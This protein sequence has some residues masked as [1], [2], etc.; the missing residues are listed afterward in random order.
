MVRT[1]TVVA[2]GLIVLGVVAM[3]GPTFGFSTV[4]GD[5][6]ISVDTSEGGDAMV[7]LEGLVADDEVEIN[8]ENDEETVI[9]IH[10]NVGSPI[11]SLITSVDTGVLAITDNGG[12]DDSISTDGDTGLTLECRDELTGSDTETVT[13]TI[14]QAQSSESGILVQQASIT[15]DVDYDCG[16]ANRDSGDFDVQDPSSTEEGTTVTFDLMNDDDAE[17][18][19]V[20]YLRVDSPDANDGTVIDRGPQNAEIVFGDSEINEQNGIELGTQVD[21]GG[22]NR[23]TIENGETVAV[24]IGAFSEDMRGKTIEL[25][26]YRQQGGGELIDIVKFDVPE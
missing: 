25:S 23:A 18:E 1:L 2:V 26:L 11:D 20:R 14:D 5:R 19:D 3:V 7:G 10:N 16:G 12:F 9:R 8:G 15:V 4:A 24:D 6:G 22:G 21:F 17:T 13:A